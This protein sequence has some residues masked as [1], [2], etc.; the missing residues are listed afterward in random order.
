MNEVV[1]RKSLF[2]V[3]TVLVENERDDGRPILFHRN[4]N[5][6][7]IYSIMGGKID[8]IYDLF[9]VLPNENPA[10]RGVDRTCLA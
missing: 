10:W 6:P 8:N 5:A 2:D 3:K 9:D 7:D 1:W 4:H